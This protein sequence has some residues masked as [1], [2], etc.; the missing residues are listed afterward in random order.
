MN[1]FL[2]KA[3]SSS[4]IIKPTN[5]NRFEPVDVVIKKFVSKPGYKTQLEIY[6]K[7]RSYHPDSPRIILSSDLYD[8]FKLAIDKYGIHP[9]PRILFESC[10]IIPNIAGVILLGSVDALNIF[11]LIGGFLVEFE[12]IAFLSRRETAA[13]HRR[14]FLQYFFNDRFK[15]STESELINIDTGVVEQKTSPEIKDTR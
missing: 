2:K 14:Q 12:F 9:L 6:S 10:I 13:Q 1:F 5:I 3:F 7:C 4:P 15:R 11:W 8:S